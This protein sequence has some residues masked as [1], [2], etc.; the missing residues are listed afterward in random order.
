MDSIDKYLEVESEQ[1]FVVYH[2]KTGQI[3]HVHTVFNHKGATTTRT[4]G[5][6]QEGEALEMAGRFG[7]PVKALS[8]LA[9]K[10]YDAAQHHTVDLKTKKLASTKPSRPSKTAKRPP[11][12]K[13]NRR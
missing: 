12:K 5:K 4:F 8:V 6:Q 10:A 2:S 3:A 13:T 1:T 9:V 11:S 7:H